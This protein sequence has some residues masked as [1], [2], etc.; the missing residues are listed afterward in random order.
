M[1]FKIASVLVITCI[2]AVL[3]GVF[4]FTP[5]VVAVFSAIALMLMTP[6]IWITGA[7]FARGSKRGFFI[8]GVA[9][10]FIAHAVALYYLMLIGFG[11]LNVS[12]SDTEARV[13]LLAIWS[14]PGV[15]A[16]VGGGLG[17]LTQW[18]VTPPKPQV[19]GCTSSEGPT[20]QSPMDNSVASASTEHPLS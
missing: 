7:F 20:T 10:G 1:Q 12:E 19:A 9:A 13:I 11:S 5:I 16:F 4:L 17:A 3:L 18:A 14:A 6:A 15:L 8:G 2:A